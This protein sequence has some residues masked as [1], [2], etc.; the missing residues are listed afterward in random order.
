MLNVVRL[1]VLRELHRRKTLSAVAV[2]MAYSTSAV[3]QQIRLLEKEIGVPL[4]EPVGRRLQLT[5]QGLI[6]VEHTDRLLELLEIAEA[7]VSSSMTQPRG[8]IRVAAFQ[9]AAAMLLPRALGYLKEEHPQL[10]V[11]FE[12]GEPEVT[13]PALVSS[14]YHL[15]IAESY[16]EMPLPIIEGISVES[17]LDDPLWLAVGGELRNELDPHLDILPQLHQMPW[18][19]EPTGSASRLWITR[20]CRKSGFEPLVTCSSEDVSVQLQFVEAGLAVA[21]L[22]GLALDRASPDVGR[23]PMHPSGS[24]RSILLATRAATQRNPGITAVAVA[25][26]RAAFEWGSIAGYENSA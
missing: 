22:P 12:Q 4:V 23:Y 25:L 11:V 7:D 19:A 17:I 14:E 8:T 26:K 13:L 18:A 6:L 20:E 3:S 5:P 15:V 16:P 10:S 1:R 2:A 9:T 21:A 24:H